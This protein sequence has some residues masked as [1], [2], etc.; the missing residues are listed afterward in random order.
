MCTLSFWPFAGGY[1]L[2]HS[3]D[4]R[5]TRA[6]GQAARAVAEARRPTLAPRDGEALG[7]W[8]AL[9]ADGR[10]LAV[11]NGPEEHA[12]PATNP[13]SRGLL[14]LELA[15]DLRRGRAREALQ[16]ELGR[17]EFR[18]FLL[19]HVER[20]ERSEHDE[21]SER[22][23]LALWRWNGRTLTEELH[24][25]PHLEVSSTAGDA[26]IERHRRRRFGELSTALRGAGPRAARRALWE[27]HHEHRAEAPAGDGFGPCMHRR[28][29]AT[30]AL[31]LIDVRGARAQL[32]H[33]P[34]SPCERAPIEGH[35]GPDQS[36]HGNGDWTSHRL[37]R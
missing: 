10:A 21:R 22:A 7:T 33:R 23:S 19:A 2:L 17:A 16:S 12:P 29:A 36:E 18:P 35:R 26:E 14:A 11:L 15:R 34:G 28:E 4:E 24:D 32:F 20:D 1:L 9:D 27:F 6:P 13:R 37:A 31:H 25:G 3:R 5:R 30:R 8:I